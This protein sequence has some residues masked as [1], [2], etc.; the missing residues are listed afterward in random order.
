[1]GLWAPGL[2]G[3]SESS[4][5]GGRYPTV[6]GE[7][8]GKVTNTVTVNTDELL[9][10]RKF[11]QLKGVVTQRQDPNL[12]VG[13]G[14]KLKEM[15]EYALAAEFF[16]MALD[17][18]APPETNYAYALTLHLS[19]QNALA[20]E[21]AAAHEDAHPEIS[22]VKRSAALEVSATYGE[23]TST[24]ISQIVRTEFRK[25]AREIVEERDA[26]LAESAGWIAYHDGEYGEAVS[27]F[28]KAD[29]WRPSDST[30]Y[31]LALALFQ[32]GSIQEAA[33]LTKGSLDSNP[34]M[35]QLYS[36]ILLHQA[37]EVR[38][39]PD[40]L[41]ADI[42]E[43][44]LKEF[45]PHILKEKNAE[46]ALVLGWYYLNGNNFEMAGVWFDRVI[47]WGGREEAYYGKALVLESLGELDGALT[48][49]TKFPEA[50]EGMRDMRERIALDQAL[51]D[52]TGKKLFEYL[53]VIEERRDSELANV[54]AWRY[55]EQD[56]YDEAKQWFRKS[57]AWGGET[58]S[59]Y[60]LALV[61]LKEGKYGE[62]ELLSKET[63]STD[64]RMASLEYMVEIEKLREGITKYDPTAFQPLNLD[65]F[66]LANK[67]MESRNGDAAL[68]FAWLLFDQEEW[69]PAQEW[70]D[71]AIDWGAPKEAY[72]GAVATRIK[73]N[74][75]K[76]AYIM[77]I[78]NM[79]AHDD[80]PKLLV[81]LNIQATAEMYE[82]GS[83]DKVINKIE[84]VD[85][86]RTLTS[87]EMQILGW[88]YYETGR[89]DEAMAVF[90]HAYIKFRDVESAD[91]LAE[92]LAGN[93][94]WSKL[95]QMADELGGPLRDSYRDRLAEEHALRG[96]RRIAADIAPEI[97][98][99]EQFEV[100]TF[101]I[102]ASI[103][104]QSSGES[105]RNLQRSTEPEVKVNIPFG[106][107]S[108][109]SFR[110]GR[111]SFS[112]GRL[113]PENLVGSPSFDTTEN[114]NTMDIEEL[115]EV[116]TPFSQKPG[117]SYDGST[118]VEV[119]WSREGFISPFV[120]VGLVDRRTGALATA[121][122]GVTIHGKASAL[123]V[124]GFREPVYQS[125]LSSVGLVDPYTGQTWGGVSEQGVR[126]SY[127]AG[128]GD[129][130]FINT[131]F[132]YS[133]LGGENVESNDHVRAAVGFTREFDVGDN[134]SYLRMGPMF[135]AS[136]YDKNL[137]FYTFG[138]GGY[139]SPQQLINSAFALDVMTAE[140]KN[141]LV[142]A[143]TRLGI[144]N[145]DS[146]DAPF[147]P[148]LGVSQPYYSG[149]SD[150]GVTFTT[151]VDAAFALSER[152]ILGLSAGYDRAADYTGW[153]AGIWM[154]YIPGL[155][156][157]NRLYEENLGD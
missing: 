22:G 82:R 1:M 7:A 57:L 85:D 56:N 143:R 8:V 17:L 53:P 10:Q 41:F 135:E 154:K 107:A 48:L 38:A 137:S 12:A 18:G 78:M 106:K 120:N 108:N 152:W 34:A 84:S 26:A 76:G 140:Q 52:A 114:I 145:Q 74:D 14:W 109:M 9:E 63:A 27:W 70:F 46:L 59:T 86:K 62:V 112:Q 118:F 67:I 47:E 61:A 134:F 4:S 15:E 133:Y 42:L 155:G 116:A 130:W 151:E 113:E 33:R 39:N 117:E 64:P 75:L 128:L 6:S 131:L 146:D 119:G 23:N 68:E 21:V 88:S 71:R 142:R 80:M 99:I 25:M 87:G 122:A 58:D 32:S 141:W 73:N 156:H 101:E 115:R 104:S 69:R 66:P 35:Q 105:I 72:Y 24:E 126:A 29:E 124:E 90:E 148:G 31:G 28:G 121:K 19:G 89:R 111:Q 92:M 83:Y 95:E 98:E 129:K 3:Q 132:Q 138:H 125:V 50:H 103:S 2:F 65:Q 150:S 43:Q 96:N 91:A 97:F 60:G 20:L 37:N 40:S 44:D 93:W 51:A 5:G 153:N 127:G 102:G 110:V 157:E 11:D 54:V 36:S 30:K 79:D 94:D 16:K 144:Y 81:D 13:L 147:F 55:M 139:Y 100:P 77:A 45:E 149:T 136:S 49:A 123:T